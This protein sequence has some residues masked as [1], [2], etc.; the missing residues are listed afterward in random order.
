MYLLH[1]GVNVVAYT[2]VQRGQSKLLGI[3]NLFF[4]LS[5]F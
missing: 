4:S 2:K 5:L 3:I 1:M